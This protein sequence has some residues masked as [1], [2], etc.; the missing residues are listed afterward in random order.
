M[1]DWLEQF[2]YEIDKVKY[3]KDIMPK[4]WQILDEV[5]EKTGLDENRVLYLGLYGSQNYRMESAS[6][7]IDCE[8]FIFPSHDDIVFAHPLTSKCLTT[9]YGTCHVKDIRAGFNELVKSSPNILE[10]F[11]SHYALVNKDYSFIMSHLCCHEINYF[12]DL[13]RPKLLKGLEGLLRRY[14]KEIDTNAKYLANAMRV[15]DMIHGIIIGKNYLD[16]LV[17]ECYEELREVKNGEIDKFIVD[18]FKDYQSAREVELE[19]Y[20]YKNFFSPDEGVLGS[21]RWDEDALMTKYIKLHF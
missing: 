1:N 4:M 14:M 5:I 8:C 21:I 15:S 19:E 6:S 18:T 17:P 2:F 7:D 10:V 20:Y 12:A 3:N 9:S 16:L 13:S 11:A